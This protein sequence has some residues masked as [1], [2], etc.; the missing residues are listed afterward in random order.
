MPG[1]VNVFSTYRAHTHA[2]TH[3][4]PGCIT[5]SASTCYFT[6]F[7]WLMTKIANF[8]GPTWGPPGSCR[9]QMGP[10]LA[11]WTLL[12]GDAANSLLQILTFPSSHLIQSMHLPCMTLKTALRPGVYLHCL[13][14]TAS[15]PLRLLLLNLEGIFFKSYELVNLGALKYLLL[16]KLHIFQCKGKTFAWNFK[17]C[18]WNFTQN[19]LSIQW[20]MWCLYKFAPAVLRMIK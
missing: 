5:P 3:S 15:S 13:T 8:M 19:T 10:M 9:P 4:R 12:S 11:P 14:W 6:I 2:L 20:N 17:W 18:L 16:N 7:L 1:Y